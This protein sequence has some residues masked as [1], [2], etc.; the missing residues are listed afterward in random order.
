M[1]APRHLCPIVR[2]MV[3]S[4]ADLLDLDGPRRPPI[5]R[6]TSC[7]NRCALPRPHAAMVGR[8]S[9]ARGSPASRLVQPSVTSKMWPPQYPA[10]VDDRPGK[11][12]LI[13]SDLSA[14]APGG[15][16]SVPNESEARCRML[17]FQERERRRDHAEPMRSDGSAERRLSEGEEL[18][19][20]G[21]AR[22]CVW[23]ASHSECATDRGMSGWQ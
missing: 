16:R 13:V 4:P 1:Q 7:D 21:D 12:M 9:A 10:A 6:S 20:G 19:S 8:T 15:M 2:R 3:H 11:S 18:P 23:S 5:P 17:P 14:D 22:A